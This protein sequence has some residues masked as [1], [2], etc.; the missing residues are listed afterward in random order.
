M[1]TLLFDELKEQLLQFDTDTL[2]AVVAYVKRDRALNQMLAE[3]TSPAFGDAL[4]ERREEIVDGTEQIARDFS[5]AGHGSPREARGLRAA[6][7]AL[8]SAG[9]RRRE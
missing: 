4:R 2:L 9:G 6:P 5:K 7:P 3:I 1:R 8:I